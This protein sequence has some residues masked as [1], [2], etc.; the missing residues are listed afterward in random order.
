MQLSIDFYIVVACVVGMRR[1]DAFANLHHD[2][3]ARQ[4]VAIDS[5]TYSNDRACVARLSCAY[6]AYIRHDIAMWKR[7]GVAVSRVR[8]ISCL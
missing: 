2:D 7:F 5:V 4:V 6:G 1:G 3:G 8:R